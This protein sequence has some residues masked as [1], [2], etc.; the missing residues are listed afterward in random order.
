MVKAEDQI[1]GYAMKLVD[2][3]ILSLRDEIEKG[4]LTPDRH[5]FLAYLLS[6]EALS[7]KDVTVISLSALLDGLSTTTPSGIYYE[8][9][10]G[11]VNMTSLFTKNYKKIVL[12]F[13][14][15]L[16]CLYCLAT[17]PRIQEKV[18]QEI[19]S[20]MGCDDP[21]TPVQGP[22]HLPTSLLVD[23]LLQDL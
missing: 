22:N 8:C 20:V 7:I 12:H 11:S 2:D 14:L 19:V 21:E 17:D 1:Y 16:F 4:T 6:R 15:V 18:Y 5:N 3:A 9:K 13:F 23:F 10:N